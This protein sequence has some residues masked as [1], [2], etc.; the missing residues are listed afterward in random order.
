APGASVEEPVLTDT[1]LQRLVPHLDEFGREAT[2][3]EL[4][5]PPHQ[6]TSL[7]D[8]PLAPSRVMRHSPITGVLVTQGCRF[9]CSYCPIPAVNQR[10][11]RQRS[12]ESHVR[13]IR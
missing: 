6:G 5:E 9:R 12:P 4:L 10:S 13:E 11:W 2:G 3:L 1:G 8:R 7:S